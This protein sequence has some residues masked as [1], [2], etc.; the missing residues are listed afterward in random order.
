V[1]GA[2]TADLKKKSGGQDGYLFRSSD[3]RQIVQAR[4]NGLTFNR[5]RP[6][7]S[8]ALFR[9]EARKHW[10]L[11]ADLAVPE[12]V[13]RLGL[14]YINAIEL[15]LGA[16][17]KEYLLTVPEIAPGVPQSLE[18]FL[19]RLAI[20][21]ERFNCKAI[22]T[23]TMKPIKNKKTND[24]E[25]RKFHFILDIDVFRKGIF[26]PDSTDIWEAFELLRDA[27]NEIFYESLTDKAKELFK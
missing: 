12:L 7:K 18:D 2:G 15:P 25:S 10:E 22:V 4:L 3:G 9:D 17:F 21:I 5:L 27:K 14:R 13:T 6:Y 24:I 20:P 23:E 11:F 26:R 19:V 16:D 8:W 1:A